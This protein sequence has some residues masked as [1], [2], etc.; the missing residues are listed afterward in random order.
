MTFQQEPYQLGMPYFLPHHTCDG[1]DDDDDDDGDDGVGDDD[2]D[3]FPGV[4]TI[5]SNLV[6][7]QTVRV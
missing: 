6:S 1:G 4:S 5:F 3:V 2:H 7:A